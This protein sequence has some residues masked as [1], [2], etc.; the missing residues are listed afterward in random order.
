MPPRFPTAIETAYA[1]TLLRRQRLIRR[2]VMERLPA[3]LARRDED[4]VT[5]VS[6]VRGAVEYLVSTSAVSSAETTA[7]LE[8]A[9]AAH[10]AGGSVAA[11][12]AAEVV[13]E[14]RA[15]AAADELRV[16]IRAV[17]RSVV[18]VMPPDVQLP[19]PTAAA[20]DSSATSSVVASVDRV[21]PIDVLADPRLSRAAVQDLQAAWVRENVALIKTMEA[22]LFADLE[23]EVL[24]AV[25]QGRTD[26]AKILEQRFGVAESRARLIARDQVA[27]L[28]GQIT[29]HR[30]TS[31][32]IKKYRWS[33]S[34]DERV[35]KSHRALDG[36]VFE[37]SDPP[38]EGHPGMPIACRCTAEAVIEDDEE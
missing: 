5:V 32:G 26:L 20:I 22:D 31:L 12:Q 6:A 1:A 38:P 19:M 35:R 9:V 11:A 34:G 2:L 17:E 8:A 7:A 25:A 36:Q 27:K 29:Q 37:W 24:K 16:V 21:I 23:A 15:A 33:S 28:N 18:S 10:A 13:A 3:V 14:A 4:D 30:Q